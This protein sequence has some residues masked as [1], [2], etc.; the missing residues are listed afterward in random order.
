MVY[1]EKL[2]PFPLFRRY[3]RDSLYLSPDGPHCCSSRAITFHGILAY[4]KM[5]QLEY[6]FY[7]LR[8]FQDGGEVGNRPPKS[9]ENPFFTREEELKDEF[10]KHLFR[11]MSKEPD[12]PV[13]PPIPDEYT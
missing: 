10:L 8:P 12:L 5:Y 9:S 1:G 13:P 3:W 4:T 7:H 6:L 2:F 11:N